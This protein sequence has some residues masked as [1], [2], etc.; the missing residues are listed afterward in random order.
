MPARTIVGSR[1]KR[2]ELKF[3]ILGIPPVVQKSWSMSVID[4][5]MICNLTSDFL[6]SKGWIK[7]NTLESYSQLNIGN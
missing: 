6:L 5:G 4:V 7:M 2:F 1:S 3:L